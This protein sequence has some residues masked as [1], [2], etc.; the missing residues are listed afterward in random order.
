MLIR[1]MLRCA[2]LIRFHCLAMFVPTG[3]IVVSVMLSLLVVTIFQMKLLKFLVVLNSKWS[4]HG[5]SK[6]L[7]L[8]YISLVVCIRNTENWRFY[9]TGKKFT[10]TV[11]ADLVV[12][13]LEWNQSCYARKI[14]SKIYT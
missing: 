9:Q 11:I 13:T 1:L 8:K 10:L 2:I 5:R 4:K 7:N 3:C 12:Q 6:R 14:S